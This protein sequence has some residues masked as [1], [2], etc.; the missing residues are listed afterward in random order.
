MSTK[1]IDTC[2]LCG[3]T[4]ERE[5]KRHGGKPI[6]LKYYFGLR[7]KPK[8]GEYSDEFL[9]SDEYLKSLPK[10]EKCVHVCRLCQDKLNKAIDSVINI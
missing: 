5:N 10:E 1:I 7:L 3:F 8:D 6:I 2:D 9:H 4:V